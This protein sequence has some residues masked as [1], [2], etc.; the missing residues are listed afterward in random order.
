MP[1]SAR[2][3]V[4]CSCYDALNRGNGRAP[5]FHD[6]DDY[7]AYVRLIREACTRVPMR[8]VGFCLM[9]NHIHLVLWPSGARDLGTWMQ[10]LLT[11]HVHGYRKR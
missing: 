5:V 2:A 7:H 10:W 6:E 11:S 3:G 1:R 4:G 8:V 9:P